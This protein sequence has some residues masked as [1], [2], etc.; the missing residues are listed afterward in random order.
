MNDHIKEIRATVAALRRDPRIT[1]EERT[2]AALAAPDLIDTVAHADLYPQIRSR[3]ER[4]RAM[5]R[6]RQRSDVE[7]GRAPAR[8]AGVRRRWSA[9]GGAERGVHTPSWQ[10]IACPSMS[11]SQLVGQNS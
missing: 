4:R 9:P 10:K 6:N 2:I 7:A 8:D 5:A 11:W 3:G 1:V